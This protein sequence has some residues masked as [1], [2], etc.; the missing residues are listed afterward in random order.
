MFHFL[1]EANERDLF[2]LDPAAT[3]SAWIWAAQFLGQLALCECERVCVYRQDKVR[4]VR[5]LVCLRACEPV[6]LLL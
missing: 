3:F 2:L 1:M 6:A 4:Y 5:S